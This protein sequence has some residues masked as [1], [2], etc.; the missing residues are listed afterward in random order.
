MRSLPTLP[1]PLAPRQLSIPFDSGKLQRISASDRRIAV[2]QL[3]RLLLEAASVAAE[4]RDD[5]ER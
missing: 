1:L 5:D 2:A 3:T 4:E